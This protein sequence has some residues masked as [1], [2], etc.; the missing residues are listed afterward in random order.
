MMSKWRGLRGLAGHPAAPQ[1]ALVE[2]DIAL[3]GLCS[4]RN[5]E[6]KL[7]E[8]VDELARPAHL[9]VPVP[10]YTRGLGRA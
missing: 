3:A 8:E 5:N 10:A 7:L 1:F 6:A 4:L 9:P 2:E